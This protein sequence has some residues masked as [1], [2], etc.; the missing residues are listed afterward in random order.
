[1]HRTEVLA[2]LTEA[3]RALF[4]IVSHIALAEVLA[5]SPRSGRPVSGNSR[6]LSPTE[7]DQLVDDYRS[8]IGSTYTLADIYSVHRTTVSMH[9][10]ELGIRLG[11]QPLNAIEVE[12][13]MDLRRGGLSLNAIGRALDRDPKYI[14][15]VL[16]RPEAARLLTIDRSDHLPHRSRH[17]L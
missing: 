11:R 10:K 9:L 15:G 14:K 6:R 16:N 3:V 2:N 7:I 5:S 8:G 4:R 1:M 13:A 17:Q 12:H